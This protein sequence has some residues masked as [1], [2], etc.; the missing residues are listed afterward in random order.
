VNAVTRRLPGGAAFWLV[1][2]A[3]LATNVGGALPTPLYPVY[4]QRFGF[5]T[6]TVTV[7]FAVYSAG[8]LAAL[9]LV[10][11]MSDSVGR[12]PVLFI[13]LAVGLVSAVVFLV[14]S[15]LHG[16]ASGITLLLLGRFLSGTSVGIVTGTATAAL[17]DFAGPAGQRRASL[18]AAAAAVV[19]LGLGPLV[20]GCLA[21][22]VSFRLVT[23]F[24]LHLALLVLAV[25]AVAIIGETVEAP[26]HWRLR[27][28]RLRVPAQVRGVM[29]FGGT[30]GFAGFAMLGLFTAVT[31]ALLALLGHHNPALTGLIVFIVFLSSAVAQLLVS[32]LGLQRSLFV[33]T[34]ML[35]IGAVGIGSSIAA[36]SLGLLIAAGVLAG[37]AQG[38]SFRAALGVVTAESP[39]PERGAVASTFFAICYLGLS[40][41]VVG[42]GI[43]IKVDG[44]V[45]AG[46]LFAALLA[47]VAVGA[48]VSLLRMSD[49][50]AS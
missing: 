41:P 20:A 43:G 37:A 14:V 5:G 30:A 36:S 26:G 27:V 1:A 29:T 10:G 15:Q 11:P 33:G 22:Y 35:A 49:R 7:I 16:H 47:V 38:L 17:A 44:L 25:L 9:V 13:G 46:E 19:G 2:F 40:L 12:R 50:A 23:S 6:L 21:E 24:V 34:G 3:F 8:A 32:R 31:P 42:V 39:P 18:T 48:L 4:Q 45:H 28:H